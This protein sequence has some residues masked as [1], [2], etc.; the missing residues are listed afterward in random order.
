MSTPVPAALLH[1]QEGDEHPLA[2]IHDPCVHAW[3]GTLIGAHL[4]QSR[5][6]E[7]LV[8]V[9]RTTRRERRMI[10]YYKGGEPMALCDRVMYMV[11]E[12][13][14]KTDD[15]RDALPTLTRLPSLAASW[16]RPRSNSISP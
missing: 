6:Q 11:N 13:I 16:K 14:R 10:R 7:R 2:L 9:I 1:L 15:P 4:L 5:L 8:T 3:I 12:D